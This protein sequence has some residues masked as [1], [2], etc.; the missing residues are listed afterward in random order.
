MFY[1]V[2]E[3]QGTKYKVYKVIN[4]NEEPNDPTNR[5]VYKYEGVFDPRR[6]MIKPEYDYLEDKWIDTYT[7]SSA[8]TTKYNEIDR[9]TRSFIAEGFEYDGHIF[10]LS[11]N[12]QRN[13]EAL[14]HGKHDIMVSRLIGDDSIEEQIWESLGFIHG[15]ERAKLY[16]TKD[17]KFYHLKRENLWEFVGVAY[18]TVDRCLMS[19][20]QE[21]EQVKVLND[22]LTFEDDRVYSSGIVIEE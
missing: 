13:I 6:D 14:N 4:V 1:T 18:M 2:L 12:A 15:D 22:I 10:S 9:K 8:L 11:N 17:N 7:L 20:I 16:P 3:K 19:G 21:K 5:F